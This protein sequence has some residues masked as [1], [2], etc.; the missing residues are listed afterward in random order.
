MTTFDRY[1]L[2]R[3]LY[4][5]VVFFVAVLGL[6]IIVDGFT[7]L[8]EFQNASRDGGTL[9]LL[10]R[11]GHHYA[12]QSL[13][14]IDL[15]GPTVTVIAAMVTLALMLRTGEIHPVLAAGVPTYRMTL[16]LLAGTVLI[17]VV[18]VVNQEVLLPR[19]AVHLFGNHGDS[20]HDAQLVK[21]QYDPKTSIWINGDSSIPGELR[22]HQPEL[23]LP[24][25]SL[26]TDIVTLRADDAV[27]LPAKDGEPAGWLLLNVNPPLK[28]IPFTKTGRQ[29][30]IPQ[31]N[32]VDAFVA[33][34]ITFDQ[35][36]RRDFSLRM[37]GTAEVI[38]RL[39][40]PSGSALVRRANLVRLHARLTRPLLNIIGVYLVIPLICRKE[41]M[42]AAQQVANIAT[43]TASL[44]IVFGLSIG[45][46]FL[47]QGGLLPPELAV[48]LPLI[49]AAAYAG[50]LSGAVRT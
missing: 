50:W 16:P 3:F 45:I 23:I 22:V 29:V 8:D 14:I 43:C 48:W 1:L 47:G 35:L 15:A 24:V 12:Y 39:Q 13:P 49:G 18:L 31:P 38:R 44:G 25:N 41:R 26:V 27:Y 10:F 42:S 2:K 19:G 30:I 33:M 46:Q 4:V 36:C 17:N 40:Q 28:E 34:A 21:P 9:D 5:T 37:V 7:N 6:F 32:G 20:S 11:M